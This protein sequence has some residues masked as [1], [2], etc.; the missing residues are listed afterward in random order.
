MLSFI[1]SFAVS[2]VLCL[3]LV[4]SS[5]YLLALMRREDLRA[6]QAMHTKPTLRLAGVAIFI[7]CW[8]SYVI[9]AGQDGLLRSLLL[10]ALPVF[11]FGLL[12]DVGFHQSPRRRLSA[13]VCSG[14]VFLWLTGTYLKDPGWFLLDPLFD[15][16]FVAVLFTLFITAGLVNAF[17][18]ID[19]L[20]GL[21]GAT[22]LVACAG[23]AYISQKAGVETV[24]MPATVIAG[25]VVGFLLLNFPFGR[26]F[27]GDSG[28]YSVGFM[29]SWLSLNALNVSDQISPWAMLMM[30]FWPIADTMLTIWRRFSAGLPVGQPDRLHFHQVVMRLIEI[31]TSGRFRRQYTNPMSTLA[32]LP[33]MSAPPA[34]AVVFWNQ[35]TLCLIA[36]W[37]SIVLFAVSYLF[38]VR[39]AHFLRLHRSGRSLIRSRF[40]Q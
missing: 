16:W 24:E 38:L 30:F 14:M 17:N 3:L 18:L 8:I 10:A 5:S 31:G 23:I 34:F 2:A 21:A 19:G 13:S 22:S 32:V 1:T 15:F 39:S 12:E 35:N 6:V 7:S 4:Q 25:A 29:L 11:V 28:A 26:L 37:L 20:N 36:F 9:F 40:A 33:L 27:L